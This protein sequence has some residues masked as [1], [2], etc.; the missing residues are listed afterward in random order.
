[1]GCFGQKPNPGHVQ[2]RLGVLASRRVTWTQIAL[3]SKSAVSMAVDTLAKIRQVGIPSL[4]GG[5]YKRCRSN[6]SMDLL[7]YFLCLEIWKTRCLH[8]YVCF[9]ASQDCLLHIFWMAGVV[10]GMKLTKLTK[11]WVQHQSPCHNGLTCFS[12]PNTEMP[13]TRQICRC[14]LPPLF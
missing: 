8:Y 2:R 13:P 4:T 5:T 9:G 12:F 6:A 7:L 3:E 10:H 14:M 11:S 1:M